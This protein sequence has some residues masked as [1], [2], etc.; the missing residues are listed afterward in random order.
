MSALAQK[1]ASWSVAIRTQYPAP[2]CAF[3]RKDRIPAAGIP[4]KYWPFAPDL[5]VEVL[6]PSDSA[7][8]VLD[9]INEWI[10]AGTR[11][12]WVVDPARKTVTSHAANRPVV[13]LRV[14]DTLDG[15]DVLPGFKL[16]VASIFT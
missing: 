12:V 13:T 6:S 9:K 8:D 4:K 16:P 7:S 2:D 3:V 14:T 5:A 11:M 1:R 15:E 10:E